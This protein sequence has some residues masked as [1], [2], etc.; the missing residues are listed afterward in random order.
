LW[1]LYHGLKRQSLTGLLLYLASGFFFYLLAGIQQ[2]GL[3]GS[4]KQIGLQAAIAQGKMA[5]VN[6]NEYLSVV[7]ISAVMVHFGLCGRSWLAL[8]NAEYEFVAL[9]NQKGRNKADALKVA[10]AKLEDAL[11]KFSDG[12]TDELNIVDMCRQ[13]RSPLKKTPVF[14]SSY[15]S[16]FYWIAAIPFCLIF[17]VN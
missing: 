17:I 13:I 9:G 5:L 16:A 1:A 15:W 12:L 2:Y 11:N 8:Q 10:K 3:F 7:L 4:N 14:D 6:Q